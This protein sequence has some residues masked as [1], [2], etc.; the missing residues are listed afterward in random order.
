M[1]WIVI[2]ALCLLCVRS[3]LALG[4][5]P[6]QILVGA[7]AGFGVWFGLVAITA[8]ILLKVTQWCAAERQFEPLDLNTEGTP[9]AFRTWSRSIIP[10]MEALGFEVRDHFR[11]SQAV[12]NATA[13]TTLFENRSSRLTAQHFTVI[14]KS[15]ILRRSE[16]VLTFTTEFTDGT[17]LYTSNSRALGLLPRIGIR[18]GSMSFPEIDDPRRLYAIHDASLAHFAGD[19]IRVDQVIE[20]PAE[21]LRTNYHKDVAKF[22]ESGYYYL[23]EK[24]QVYRPTWKGST[25]MAWKS[26]WPVK[27]VRELLWRRR[28]ARLLRELGLGG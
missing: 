2:V 8:P 4:S 26:L 7:T 23:V 11:L 12:P 24:R 9:Q 25:L 16:T 3:F 1:T 17:K 19:G 10:G 28:A 14:A 5:S 22:A 15:G 13:F 20:D 21:F 27:P 6:T 18:E